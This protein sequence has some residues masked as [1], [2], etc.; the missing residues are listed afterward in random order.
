MGPAENPSRNTHLPS[1]LLPPL[2]RELQSLP[3]LPTS[4][5]VPRELLHT[6]PHHPGLG[7][8]TTTL[9]VCW[10]FFFFFFPGWLQLIK[11]LQQDVG[12]TAKPGSRSAGAQSQSRE[13]GLPPAWLP[14]RHS[15]CWEAAR[16][17]ARAGTRPLP[18]L[19][20]LGNG[21]KPTL[22]NVPT[23]RAGL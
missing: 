10:F 23:R 8:S 12:I 19:A 13:R 11:D 3:A 14:N 2:A 9:W 1:S 15:S 20:L 22:T 21:L 16:A 17:G 18:S 7:A 6:P 4:H 5:P